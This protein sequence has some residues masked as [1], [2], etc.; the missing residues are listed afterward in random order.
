MCETNI[1]KDLR[2][3]AGMTQQQVA[4][5]MPADVNTIQNYE[6]T[7]KVPKESLHKLLD[8]Y[9]VSDS[10]RDQVVLEVYGRRPG[11]AEESAADN[12]PDFLFQDQPDIIK[13]SKELNLTAREMDLYGYLTI[14]RSYS[15]T[16]RSGYSDDIAAINFP[17]D[18][19][20]I[21]Q[22][23][24]SFQYMRAVRSITQRTGQPDED[25][26]V[27]SYGLRNPEKPFSFRSME[28]K[29]IMDHLELVGRD[30]FK[31]G[32][33]RYHELYQICKSVE[34][35]VLIGTS[36]EHISDQLPAAVRPFVNAW[37]EATN[38]YCVEDDEY[39]HSRVPY[40]KSDFKLYSQCVT[41]WKEESTNP[42]Y[43]KNKQQYVSD[44]NAYDAHPSL[45]DKEPS[46]DFRVD[47]K[48]G[49][50]DIGRQYLA[51]CGEES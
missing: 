33:D 17:V 10:E 29:N 28:K 26:L 14:M 45:Y 34:N 1:L 49:L 9:G 16:F 46:F 47:Y 32:S 23:G 30:V 19:Q 21:E 37:D 50:T 20:M 48:I 2:I 5:Q 43:I 40:S 42:D 35:P 6:R 44:R 24:G 22:W 27:F 8:I 3:K 36:G 4:D 11:Q 12:F 39:R 15:S 7:L 13:R 51:W 41:I 18:Y 31:K 25:S 38:T